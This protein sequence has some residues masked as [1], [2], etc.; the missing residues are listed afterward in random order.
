[1]I[2]T[3]VTAVFALALVSAAQAMPT[4]SVHQPDGISLSPLRAVEGA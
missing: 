1:M 4:G 3:L 2:R